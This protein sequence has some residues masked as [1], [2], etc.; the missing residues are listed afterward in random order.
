MEKFVISTTLG[1]AI[2]GAMLTL[3]G[4]KKQIAKEIKES[5]NLEASIMNQRL[6]KLEGLDIMT[7]AA[8]S[9]LCRHNEKLLDSR[10]ETITQKI[11]SN[12]EILMSKVDNIIEKVTMCPGRIGK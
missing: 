9:D 6:A 4:I 5:F 1:G 3:F 7:I 11:E 8:H 2:A 12:H 10:L